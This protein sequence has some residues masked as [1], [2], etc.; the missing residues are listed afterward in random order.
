MAPNK[1]ISIRNIIIYLE[2]KFCP[3]RR[4]FVF[5][6]P[7]WTQNGCHSK[8]KWSPYGAACLTPGKYP[9]PLKAFNFLILSNLFLFFLFL[10][11]R[12]FWNGGHFENFKTKSTILSDDLFLCQVSKGSV[13]RHVQLFSSVEAST[14]YLACFQCFLLSSFYLVWIMLRL[15]RR[16]AVVW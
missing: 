6:W 10:Y 4:I 11:W 13:V 8:P 3:N 12:S 15:I 5:W 9:F 1:W 7:F 14:S 2:T 16:P